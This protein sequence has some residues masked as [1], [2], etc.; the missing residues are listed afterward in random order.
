LT[1]QYCAIIGVAGDRALSVSDRAASTVGA[2]SAWLSGSF[3]FDTVDVYRKR[4]G[5]SA[6]ITR[7]YVAVVGAGRNR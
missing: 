6:A 4:K 2:G 7:G 3:G 1:D 5:Y